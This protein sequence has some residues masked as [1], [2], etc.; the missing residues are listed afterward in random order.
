[1]IHFFNLIISFNITCKINGY[2][3]VDLNSTSDVIYKGRFFLEHF[4][5]EK[6]SPGICACRLVDQLEAGLILREYAI[7]CN[8]QV[9]DV[10]VLATALPIPAFD[11]ENAVLVVEAELAKIELKRLKDGIQIVH[12]RLCLM[13]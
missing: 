12:D 6:E 11:S 5:F 7:E 8:V 9:A 10:L 2:S 13:H 1:M 3:Q 4:L